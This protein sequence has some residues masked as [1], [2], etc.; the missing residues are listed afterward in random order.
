M[1]RLFSSVVAKLLLKALQFVKSGDLSVCLFSS[2]LDWKINYRQC[3]CLS[4]GRILRHT[5]S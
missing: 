4:H 1:I 5:V 2:C 3:H